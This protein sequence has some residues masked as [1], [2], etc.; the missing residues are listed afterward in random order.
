MTRPVADAEDSGSATAAALTAIRSS[1]AGERG[2]QPAGRIDRRA[3][4]ICGPRDPLVGGASDEGHELDLT[5]L[6][7]LELGRND[8]QRDPRGERDL[9]AAGSAGRSDHDRACTVDVRHRERQPIRR[10]VENVR[11]DRRDLDRE[12]ASLE[13]PPTDLDDVAG[14]RCSRLDR[15]DAWGRRELP[16]RPSR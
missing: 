1:R 14:C 5:T 12:S 11:H 15:V 8:L 9:A 4:G 10:D 13:P 16:H 3:A 7:D 6:V 2:G